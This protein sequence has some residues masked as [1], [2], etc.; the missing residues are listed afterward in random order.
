MATPITNHKKAINKS[1]AF[2]RANPG[3]SKNAVR[4]HLV[5]EFNDPEITNAMA[6]DELDL[7]KLSTFELGYT[8]DD[9]VPWSKFRNL[10]EGL[11]GSQVKPFKDVLLPYVESTVQAE[12]NR[13]QEQRVAAVANRQVVND[14]IDEANVFLAIPVSNSYTVTQL[15]L[16]AMQK[17]KGI[18][19]STR[20]GLNRVIDEIDARLALLGA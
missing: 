8:D 6:A 9:T 15:G 10:V 19:R 11:V 12:I 14:E 3:S 5:V 2:I 18:N 13:L 17:G 1:V 20:D 4:D 16:D 7:L